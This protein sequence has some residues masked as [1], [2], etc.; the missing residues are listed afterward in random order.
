MV[1]IKFGT[2]GWRA[3]IAHDYTTDN[4]ARVAMGTALWLKK[5]YDAPKVVI[6]H[7]CRFGGPMFTEVTAKVL[8]EQGVQVVI[9][10]G[11]TTTPMVSMGTNR[12][13]AHMGVVITASHNPP[14]YNGYKLKS[15]EG[16]PSDPADVTA[17][18]EL[19]PDA[20]T[21]PAAPL[22]TYIDK[23][24][25]SY[26][27]LQQLYVDEVKAKFDL[28]AIKNAGIGVVYDPMYGAGYPI[29]NDILPDAVVLHKD[30]NPGFHGRAPE[31]IAKNLP[32]LAQLM[33]ER[34]D[35]H[36]GLATDGD[37]DRIG[38]FDDQGNFVD[39]HH[40]LLLL[41]HYLHKY[42]GMNGKVVVAFSA[43]VKVKKLCE[44]YGLPIEIT[45]IGFKHISPYMVRE[46]VLVGGE[47][48]GGIAV[49][50]HIPE[51]DGIWDGLVILEFMAKTGKS[52]RALIQEV[53]DIVGPF[54]YNRNDLHLPEEKKQA[55]IEKA[56]TVGFDR[57]GDYEVEKVEDKDG[58]KHYLGGDTTLMIRPSGT[59]PLL[60]VYC[61]APDR[62]TVESILAAARET[63]LAD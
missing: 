44:H 60:R 57:F 1:Q 63:L 47:E 56:R 7:D 54:A 45:K 62:E 23:G 27:D 10:E 29:F 9:G 25:V 49:K 26:T 59:E 28:A 6:G 30:H 19:I 37:A 51:R 46:D 35:L 13:D 31:P 42:K 5:H 4:V 43:S 15:A 50:G 36:V 12:L 2:D 41:I 3:I 58:F 17:V 11:I 18:E 61:E 38:L 34:D 55:I 33:A 21:I 48:S 53:Y 52:L 22:Q 8:A 39:A 20:A 24:V 32:E 40:V 16:G 14:T